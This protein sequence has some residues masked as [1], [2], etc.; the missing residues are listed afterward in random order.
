MLALLLRTACRMNVSLT[1]DSSKSICASSN[2][3]ETAFC[4]SHVLCSPRPVLDPNLLLN[5]SGSPALTMPT[6]FERIQS[7]EYG[8]CEKSNAGGSYTLRNLSRLALD[9]TGELRGHMG[10]V[11]DV[12]WSD[13][14]DIL[15]SSGDDCTIQLWDASRDFSAVKTVQTGAIPCQQSYAIFRF[16]VN[17]AAL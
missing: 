2:F 17:E 14:G 12:C 4:C 5:I 1:I 10:C 15:I 8:L 6:F 13:S 11:N 3:Y 7:R 9:E 16:F